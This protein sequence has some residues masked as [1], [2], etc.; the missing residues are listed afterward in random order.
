MIKM[1]NL[2]YSVLCIGA[3][4]L[5]STSAHAGHLKDN[6][7]FSAKIDGSQAV[8]AVTTTALGVGSFM[9]NNTRDELCVNIA[10]TGLSGPITGAHIHD[11][12]M[13]MSG[14]ILID[15][16]SGISGNQI[17]LTIT[18]ADLTSMV[19]S[20]LI[21]GE[22]YINI[23]TAANPSGEIRGQIMLEADKN[24]I[25]DAN[26]MQ[27]VPTVATSAFGLGKFTL[28][29]DEGLV[30]YKFVAQGLSGAITAAHLHIGA[31]GANGS[32]EQDLSADIAGNV[33][34]GSFVP[35]A[36]LL[37][38]LK[39]GD[40]YVNVHTMANPTGEIRGQLIFNNGIAF[41]ALIDGN[42]SVPAITTTAS[43]VSSMRLN[44]TLDTVFYDIVCDGLSGSITG[45]HIHSAD[46][47]VSGPISV[48]FSSNINGNRIQ[49]FFTS[50][51]LTTTLINE[52][53]RGET[54]LNIHTNI[55]PTGE[56][57][58]QVYRLAR[59]GYTT[60]INGT[61]EVPAIT[62]PGYGAGVVS[63]N[64]DQTNLHY[65]FVVGDLSGPNS[66]AHIHNAMSGST[67]GI[68]YDLGSAFS[69]V[70][71][72]D[73]AFG[74][75]TSADLTPFSP[76]ESAMFIGDQAYLNIHTSANPT[77]EVRGQIKPGQECYSLVVGIEDINQISMR[78][79]PNPVNDLLYLVSAD[80]PD[81]ISVEILDITGKVVK[82][83]DRN[84]NGLIQFVIPMQEL[85]AG[86]YIITIKNQN[87][88]LYQNKITKQ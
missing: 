49:G 80:F 51:S 76:T 65:M 40:V 10:V 25:S 36:L 7:L 57:R 42:Q 62:V 23:H 32:I 18:S 45:A 59:E 81:E 8:P 41:D 37:T 27:L 50:A 75:W 20:K 26:G 68:I 66:G 64:R 67:G 70:G 15:L 56:I 43:G 22:T 12:A 2:F 48:D 58:G 21:L 74:Y 35:S 82:R 30:E 39:S 87:S 5:F 53:L 86:M 52:M 44:S 84:L 31:V 19:L 46:V 72:N 4:V 3:L 17:T 78:M 14:S 73:S 6:L 33:I 61:Q 55:N 24:Y 83:L 79:Y 34:E 11:G 13:G 63:V 9:L 54:Y 77:G 85:G 71:T 1:K 88:I 16:S 28:N 29:M 60:I 38:S 47:G 69:G